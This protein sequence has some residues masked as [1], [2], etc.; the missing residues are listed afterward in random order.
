[1]TERVIACIP[2]FNEETSISMVVARARPHVAEVV[3]VDDGSA[4]QTAAVAR[5]AGATVLVHEQNRGKGAAI[6]T[7][8]EY[9]AGSGASLVIFLDADGQ[10]APEEIPKFIAAARDNNAHIVVGN[11]M[12]DT[13]AMPWVRLL[14]NRF[15]SWLTS[16]VAGQRIYDSQCGYRLLRRDALA[17]LRLDSVRFETET[18]MLI[19]AGR[20]GQKIANVGIRTIYDPARRSRVRPVP[21]TIRFFQLIWRYR[22]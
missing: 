14:T 2:A 19:Q 16:R 12:E 4:D 20:A 3:V 11:R 22:R 7:A 5:Q 15:T 18:E 10:H 1:M 21:D 8:L 13:R 9:F 17:S 6:A